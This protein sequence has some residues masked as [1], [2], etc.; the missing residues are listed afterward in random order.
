MP[1][2]PYYN[3]TAMTPGISITTTPATTTAAQKIT[4][5]PLDRLTQMEAYTARGGKVREIIKTAAPKL[6]EKAVSI[7]KKAIAKRKLKRKAAP[8][9]RS[10]TPVRKAPVRRSAVRGF[11]D[12]SILF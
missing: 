3:A 11:D 1:S 2:A 10:T 12:L 7:I 8:V 9:K 5:R 4:A 6:K